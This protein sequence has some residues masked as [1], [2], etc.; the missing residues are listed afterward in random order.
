[1]DKEAYSEEIRY[2]LA[3]IFH[4]LW[5]LIAA[6]TIAGAIAFAVSLNIQPVYEATALVMIEP[7]NTSSTDYNSVLA[8]E[9]LAK[10]YSERMTTRP[11]LE[12]V[13]RRLGLQLD[14]RELEEMIE[15]R[16]VRDTQL[17]EIT[18]ES[19]SP[20]QAAE[21]AN[22]LFLEFSEKDISQ[23]TSRFKSTRQNLEEQLAQLDILIDSTSEIINN[24]D[25]AVANQSE[26]NRLE[27]ALTEYYQTYASLL[28]SYEQVRLAEA[29]FTSIL[30]LDEPAI[31]SLEPVRP[32]IFANTILA[33]ILG[34]FFAIGAIFLIE[35]LDDTVHS[36]ED[37]RRHLNLPVLA[38]IAHYQVIDD[39][40]IAATQP[41]AP[42]VEAFRLLRTNLDFVSIDHPMRK[43]LIVSPTPQDGKS[44]I[45]TNLAIVLAQSDRQVLLLD[46]DMRRPM[47]HRRL[48]LSN[49]TGLSKLFLQ[50]TYSG[51]ENIHVE[52][53]IQQ[54]EFPNVSA[55]TSGNL[56]PNPAELLGSNKMLNM[57]NRLNT[58]Y[59]VVVIDSP[60]ILAVTDGVVL[61]PHVDGVLIVVKPGETKLRECKQTVE[62][63]R[64]VGANLLGVVLNDIPIKKASYS[65]NRYLNYYYPTDKNFD[66]SIEKDN[67]NG[68]K[69]K[70]NEKS[71]SM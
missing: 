68:H 69:P 6:A 15:V 14:E 34:L 56:P 57:L 30:T 18:A 11:V 29:Q 7:P 37:V 53:Y 22:A 4:W 1:M 49:Q 45:A 65:N 12:G 63:L 20:A 13:A 64:R 28:Q 66:F 44:T 3:L 21:I 10:T 71:R 47:I 42:V 55:L 40:P 5:L 23:Q 50:P 24:P 58:I 38:M 27:T 36:P 59:E 25:Q 35:S 51:E 33:V 70:I 8:S 48:N 43:L 52:N 46:S 61:A 32:R 26:R 17:I 19:N 62:Q 67:K 54:T 2:Y 31:S 60:P 41:R 16:A 39:K 9:R